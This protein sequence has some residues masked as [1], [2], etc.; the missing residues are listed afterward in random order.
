MDWTIRSGKD[1]AKGSFNAPPCKAAE[2]SWIASSLVKL[3]RLL[4]VE[5][6]A[7]FSSIG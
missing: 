5:L 4:L 6:S 1:A 2:I 3:I 7:I